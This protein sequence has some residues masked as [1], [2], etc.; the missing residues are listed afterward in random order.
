M[1]VTLRLEG[2]LG[3]WRREKKTIADWLRSGGGFAQ[4]ADGAQTAQAERE[5]NNGRPWES[6]L[7]RQRQ[8]RTALHSR[9]SP[10]FFKGLGYSIRMD[11][12]FCFCF[13]FSLS[14][15]STSRKKKKMRQRELETWSKKRRKDRKRIEKR[16]GE[17]SCLGGIKCEPTSI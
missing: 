13:L 17:K 8:L 12:M 2:L 6:L 14:P 5:R 16:K 11:P 10:W 15:D 9:K 7:Y 1:R 3:L 4:N